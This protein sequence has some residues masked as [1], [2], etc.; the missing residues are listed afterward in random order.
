METLAKFLSFSIAF[1][2]ITHSALLNVFAEFDPV[3]ELSLMGLEIL[4]GVFLQRNETSDGYWPNSL[5]FQVPWLVLNFPT[6]QPVKKVLL[7]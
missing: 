7:F 6:W 3:R 5:H 2:S 4:P 1:S